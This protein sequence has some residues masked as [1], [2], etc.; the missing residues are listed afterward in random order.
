MGVAGCWMLLRRCLNSIDR[1]NLVKH[2]N[3]M[4]GAEINIKKINRTAGT[5]GIGAVIS[6][7]F[8]RKKPPYN[9]K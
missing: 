3:K 9:E 8:I 4:N 1:F 7:I 5:D 2:S 6:H